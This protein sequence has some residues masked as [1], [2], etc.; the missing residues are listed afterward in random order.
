MNLLVLLIVTSI[1]SCKN[2]AVRHE[3]INSSTSI[4]EYPRLIDS[5]G[6]QSIYDDARWQLYVLQ[7]DD[8]PKLEDESFL[9]SPI[10]PLGGLNLKFESLAIAGDTT[11]IY[12]SFTT[13]QEVEI[14]N[15]NFKHLRQ[16]VFVGKRYIKNNDSFV[17]YLHRCSPTKDYYVG[18]V[19]PKRIRTAKDRLI[20]PLQPDVVRYINRN[21]KDLNQWFSKE[22]VK[23]GIIK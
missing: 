10:K 5:L 2:D 21:R 1:Y 18:P 7:C 6:L 14:S 17:W 9:F 3:N 11:D 16:N 19:D 12:F 22:A 15:C 4:S 23:R 13:D 20:N 8:T